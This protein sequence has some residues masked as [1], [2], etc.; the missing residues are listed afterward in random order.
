MAD[1][2]SG[3]N[4]GAPAGQP[5]RAADGKELRPLMMLLLFDG[6]VGLWS[7]YHAPWLQRFFIGQIP[8]AGLVGLVWGF[9]E[10]DLKK[11]VAARIAARLR[12]PVVYRV[13]AGLTV[14]F[15]ILTVVRSTVEVRALDPARSEMLFRVNGAPRDVPQTGAPLDKAVCSPPASP[16][17]TAARGVA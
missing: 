8:F 12:Q 14:A 7:S 4:N 17:N 9:L 13:L 1:E 15:F 10:G 3:P 2:V 16:S 6:A 11:V 5:A